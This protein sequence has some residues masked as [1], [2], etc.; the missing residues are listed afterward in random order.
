MRASFD[1]LLVLLICPRHRLGLNQFAVR[2]NCTSV[3]PAAT[4]LQALAAATA[5]AAARTALAAALQQ[6]VHRRGRLPPLLL[7]LLPRQRR[8]QLVLQ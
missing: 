2:L 8:D 4:A 6:A 3:S 5:A 1:V 7:L